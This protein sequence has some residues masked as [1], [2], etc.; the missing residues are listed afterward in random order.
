[1]QFTSKYIACQH[2]KEFFNMNGEELRKSIHFTLV[3]DEVKT[4]EK[5][6]EETGIKGSSD[7]IRFL[8]KQYVART[9]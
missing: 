8:L 5:I 2:K 1:M 4:L 7:I 9:T 6:K 3:G